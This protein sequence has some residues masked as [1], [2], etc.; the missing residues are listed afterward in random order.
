MPVD[1]SG[2]NAGW[3]FS[4]SSGIGSSPTDFSEASPLPS[5]PNFAIIQN[6][7]TMS[8]SFT[9]SVGGTHTIAMRANVRFF[10]NGTQTIK[11]KVDG[12]EVYSSTVGGILRG[13]SGWTSLSIPVGIPTVGNH[14]LSIEGQNSTGDETAFIDSVSITGPDSNPVALANGNLDTYS[15]P[16]G[17]FVMNPPAIATA[18]YRLVAKIMPSGKTLYCRLIKISDGSTTTLKQIN[19]APTIKVNGVSRGAVRLSDP[20]CPMI[21]D[22]AHPTFLIPLPSGV[23]IATGDDV[24]IS[25]S[26][27]WAFG[28]NGYT[29]AMTDQAVS[30]RVGQS[31]MRDAEV[32]RTMGIG[33]SFSFATTLEW[34]N[35]FAPKNQRYR[36][37]YM[38]PNPTSQDSGYKPIA[39]GSTV[40]YAPVVIINSA[41]LSNERH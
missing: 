29:E 31:A 20:T 14:T 8:Q 37:A 1:I 7:G 26:Q 41:Q 35:G 27:G 4:P 9:T 16:A 22:S 33:A 10:Q 13:G 40:N 19:E 36:C 17:T 38:N 15:L 3:T 34:R 18:A 30:V 23:S 24:R 32:P 11:V 28:P 39:L 12:S 6:L 25:G 2:Y 21:A 5:S